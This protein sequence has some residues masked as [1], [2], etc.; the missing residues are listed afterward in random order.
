MANGSQSN[1]GS[2]GGGDYQ[3]T[4]SGTN[5]QV[6]GCDS[7]I[8]YENKL[9]I[10]AEARAIITAAATTGLERAIA[11]IIATRKAPL[12]MRTRFDGS[13]VPRY[14]KMRAD[15]CSSVLLATVATTIRIRM[16]RTT[17]TV[18]ADMLVTMLLV[19]PLRAVGR[20]GS[21]RFHTMCP[22]HDCCRLVRVSLL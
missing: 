22:S 3:Y 2:S 10:H 5:S 14:T 1:S 18:V 20:V 11:T 6:C 7:T 13:C 17:T 4:G 8:F 15:Q 12:L 16:A 21:R 9:D 19:V